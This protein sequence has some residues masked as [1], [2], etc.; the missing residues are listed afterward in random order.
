MITGVVLAR[1]EQENIVDCMES[2]RPH[3]GEVILIDMESTDKT[4]ELARPYVSKVISHPLVANFDPARNM[5]IGAAQY[6]WLWF[7]DADERIPPET[8]RLIN[9]IVRQRGSEIGRDHDSIQNL[10]LRAMDAAL[11]LV[12]RLHHAASAQARALRL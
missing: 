2:F 10:F 1:N 3:V 5:A 7:L 11:W 9:E 12:A 8:G 4:V 6:E